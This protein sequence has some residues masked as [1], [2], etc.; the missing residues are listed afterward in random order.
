MPEST[1]KTHVN[2]FAELCAAYGLQKA[3]ISP[4]SRN[5]PLIMAFHFQHNIDCYIIP[6]ERSAA[7]FA[8]GMAQYTGQPVAII[9]TSG[10]AAL[11]YTP[12]MAEAYYQQLPLVAITAD[13]PPEWVDQMDGQTINQ[14]SIY[15][16]FTVFQAQLPSE[17]LSDSDVWY[18]KRLVRDGFKL[19]INKQ[20]P[21]HFNVPLREPLYNKIEHTKQTF[22]V[23]IKPANRVIEPS[24]YP[25]LVDEFKKYA[26]VLLVVGMQR[27][28]EPLASS[29][30]ELAYSRQVVVLSEY[31]SNI[32]GEEVFIT[33][34][35]LIAAIHSHKLPSFSPDL[36]IS[37]GD[38]LL[39]KPLKQ[40]IRSLQEAEHWI[41]SENDRVPDV[42]QRIDRIVEGK[43]EHFL[44]YL[45]SHAKTNTAFY[46]EWQKAY[47]ILNNLHVTFT[48]A[49]EWSDMQMFDILSQHI[50]EDTIIH[51]GNSSP[52]RYAQFFRWN[53]NIRFF[54]NRGTAG[55]DGVTSTAL[56]M[57]SQTQ[58][59]VTLIT[60]DV[61]FLYDSNAMWNQYKSGNFKIIVIN[62]KGGNIFSMIDGPES[63]GLLNDYFVTHIPVSIDQLCN[64]YGIGYYLSQGKHD[65]VS[66]LTQLYNHSSCAILEVQ[67]DP[68]TNTRV[69]KEYFATIKSYFQHEYTT[70]ENN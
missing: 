32:G 68:K 29:I 34:D 55:I 56:G 25:Q 52:V 13:R 21:V 14:D 48:N 67:T 60:G 16:N 30:R 45:L 51:L 64:A 58:K 15:K 57:A 28:N 18:I 70:V 69:W 54:S 65:L 47:Q 19:L 61:S 50:P 53:S 12:A 63:T 6:D 26:N 31:L 23:D 37:F 8:L 20:K 66:G 22:K 7:Y 38:I 42:F 62:N 2:L 24:I 39:S 10:T 46:S 5:A 17:A 3:V 44:S 27:P 4:G 36:F 35:A 40:W 59:T 1:D 9:C 41:V 43:P 33:S 11:N 49:I